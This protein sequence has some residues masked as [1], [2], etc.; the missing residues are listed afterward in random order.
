MTAVAWESR[1]AV[2]DLE[3]APQVL[4]DVSRLPLPTTSDPF[5]L[6]WF[7]HTEFDAVHTNL[8]IDIGRMM[9]A[10]TAIKRLFRAEQLTS[11][12][13][14]EVSTGMRM[15]HGTRGAHS[16]DLTVESEA[17]ALNWCA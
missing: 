3:C 13:M 2:H 7:V 6:R 4:T 10:E 17:V 1:H 14:V 16:A 8:P 12:S 11:M 5:M 9:S 15:T